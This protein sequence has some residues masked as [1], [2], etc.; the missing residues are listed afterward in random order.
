MILKSDA[1]KIETFT[2]CEARSRSFGMTLKIEENRFFLY[3]VRS[4]YGAFDTIEE[5]HQFLCG[6]ENTIKYGIQK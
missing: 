2:I 1:Q 6:V 5:I 4:C 3:K